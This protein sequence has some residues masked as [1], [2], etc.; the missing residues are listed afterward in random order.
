MHDVIIGSQVVTHN[1][2]IFDEMM[3]IQYTTDDD[4]IKIAKPEI[5]VFRIGAAASS[6]LE[7]D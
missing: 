7:S 4:G 3:T 2:L 5:S 6:V 1:R